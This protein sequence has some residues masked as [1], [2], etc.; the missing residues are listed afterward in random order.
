MWSLHDV[1]EEVTVIKLDAHAE[2]THIAS[3]WCALDLLKE[4]SSTL[5]AAASV[6]YGMLQLF[7]K[8]SSVAH[9]TIQHQ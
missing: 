5:H 8:T 1:L 9:C 4:C 3:V 6:M 2:H 7:R